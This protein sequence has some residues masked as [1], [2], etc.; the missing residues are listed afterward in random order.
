M[1]YVDVF[2]RSL[3]VFGD[4][5]PLFIRIGVAAVFVVH[6]Y[7]KLFTQFSGTVQFFESISLKPAK[8]WVVVVG[9]VEFFGGLAVALGFLT[10][11]AALLIAVDMVGATVLVKFKQRFVGGWEF[12]FVLLTSAVALMLIGAGPFSIDRFLG[13]G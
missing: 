9:V 4:F 1:Y 7:P 11:L 13:W 5:A 3:A 12:D 8:F 2:S 6:G 10:Q